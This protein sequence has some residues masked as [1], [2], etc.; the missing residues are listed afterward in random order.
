IGETPLVAQLNPFLS[1]RVLSCREGKLQFLPVL[2]PLRFCSRVAPGWPVKLDGRFSAIQIEDSVLRIVSEGSNFPL[3]TM[4]RPPRCSAPAARD[5]AY[6]DPHS[7]SRQAHPSA[8]PAW[9]DGAR[10]SDAPHGSAR[11]TAR[12]APGVAARRASRVA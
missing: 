11:V 3:G 4:F 5:A 12:R 8:G 9:S 10:Q 7:P 2:G 6:G 1:G